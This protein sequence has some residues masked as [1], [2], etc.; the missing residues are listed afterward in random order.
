M[1]LDKKDKEILR[2]LDDKGRISY[3]EL[4]NELDISDVAAKKR[5]S[6]LNEEGAI[7]HFTVELD[8]KKIGKDLRG[9][10]LVKS[11]PDTTE[12]IQKDFEDDERVLDMSKTMG[13]YDLVIETACRDL[14]ELKR[15]SERD[16]GNLKGV[17]EIRTAI[18]TD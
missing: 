1:E 18:V 12:V 15:L 7:D 14:D 9:Y 2:I 6:K 16:I 10:L 4:G 3:T 13:E 11:S 17:Q 5:V 8:Y